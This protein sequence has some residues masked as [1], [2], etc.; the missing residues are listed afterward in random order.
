MDTTVA[1]LVEERYLLQAQPAGLI[2]ALSRRGVKVQVGTDALRD[3]GRWVE[4]LGR[5]GAIVARGRSTSLLAA[6]RFAEQRGCVV[7]DPAR[8]IAGVRDKIVMTRRL[9]AAG[10]PIPNTWSGTLADAYRAASVQD[11]PLICKPVYGDNGRGLQ[12]VGSPAALRRLTWREPKLLAQH[13]LPSDGVDLKL[14]VIGEHVSA[15]H[16]PSPITACFGRDLGPVPVTAEMRRIA[17]RCGR[18][19]GLSVFGVDCLRTPSGL[20]VIEVNDFPNF[21]SVPDAD[22]RLAAHVCAAMK[23]RSPESPPEPERGGSS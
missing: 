23:A 15:V 17:A 5:I 16:K 3:L 20:V 14:Y 19:F 21:T 18:A 6:L 11:Y 10:I 2:A 4:S 8:A 1:V 9:L 13:Y 22:D 12:V 7:V